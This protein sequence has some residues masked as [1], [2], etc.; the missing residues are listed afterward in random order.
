MA[1]HVNGSWS[2]WSGDTIVELTDGSVG[3]RLNC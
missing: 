2:G 1:L 3:S